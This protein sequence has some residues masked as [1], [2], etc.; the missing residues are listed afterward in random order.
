MGIFPLSLLT[1]PFTNYRFENNNRII[2]L[3][4]LF[5]LFFAS[6]F[7]L[8][9]IFAAYFISNVW[10][11]WKTSPLIITLSAVATSVT[12]LPF[13]GISTRIGHRFFKEIFTKSNFRFHKSRHHLQYESSSKE[14]RSKFHQW[15]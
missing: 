4:L 9:I 3:P 13:P 2:G 15:K 10:Y 1:R 14:R 8:V 12:D 6:M 7:V 11:K 5:R